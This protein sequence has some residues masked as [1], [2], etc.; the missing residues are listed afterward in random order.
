MRELR[1]A[2]ISRKAVLHAMRQS[3]DADVRAA[4]CAR[5]AARDDHREFCRRLVLAAE[6]GGDTSFALSVPGLAAVPLAAALLAWEYFV[7]RKIRKR[8]QALPKIKSWVSR[9][10][11]TFVLAAGFAPILPWWIPVGQPSDKTLA[12]LSRYPGLPCAVSWSAIL[13]VAVVLCLRAE[14]R[15]LLLGRGKALAGVSLG[16]LAMFLALTLWSWSLT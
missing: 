16:A 9:K 3:A 6:A 8:K 15:D 10:I 2:D 14:T 11:L 4:I 12:A 1:I 7:W 5:T 13:F